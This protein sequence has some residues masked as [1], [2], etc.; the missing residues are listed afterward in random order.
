[1]AN[2]QDYEGAK[3]RADAIGDTIRGHMVWLTPELT[4]QAERVN[5]LSRTASPDRSRLPG[6]HVTITP[7][8]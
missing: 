5:L 4:A 1:M 6:L 3:A 7:E 2:P 8:D